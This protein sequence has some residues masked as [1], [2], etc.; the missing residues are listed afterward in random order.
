[1]SDDFADI[2]ARQIIND[3]KVFLCDGSHFNAL[4]A[5]LPCEDVL[6]DLIAKALREAA[7]NSYC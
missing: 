3:W 7:N 5:E 1:M 6:I 2:R 4:R